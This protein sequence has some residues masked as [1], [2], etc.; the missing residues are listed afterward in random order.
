MTWHKDGL[1]YENII[2][3]LRAPYNDYF[4]M[5]KQRAFGMQIVIYI[6]SCRSI[7]FTL[8]NLPITYIRFMS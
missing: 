4:K 3:C 7:R 6:F 8:Y 5:L 1:I 2:V